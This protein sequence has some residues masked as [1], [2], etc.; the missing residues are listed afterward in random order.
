[1]RRPAPRPQAVIRALVFCVLAAGLSIFG[2]FRPEEIAQRESWEEF[3]MTAD[4]A[5]SELIGEG[6]TK[7]WRLYLKKGEIE[8]RAAWKHVEAKSDGIVDKWQHEI[9]AYRIDKL[10]GLNMIPVT[11]E[12]EFKG[13]KGSLALWAEN[14]YSLLKIMEDGIE[15][16]ESVFKQFDDMKYIVRFFDSLIANDDRT[17]QNTLYTADWRT[18]IFDHSR[19]FQSSRKYTEKLVF[20]ARGIKET[21]D[22][23]PFLIRRIPRALLEK[24]KALT[25]ESIRQAV[26]PYLTDKE[27]EAV[28]ARKALVLDEIA[29][30]IKQDGEEKVLY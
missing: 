15:I 17:Q 22:G 18:I 5:K 3:L 20:G 25:L 23:K 29:E 8:H 4:I 1:M 26:G 21:E 30:M 7:P 2:Q 28:I 13:K 11:V 10:I 14:K 24:V 12:R 27:S 9:A 16:P 19:A 6:V